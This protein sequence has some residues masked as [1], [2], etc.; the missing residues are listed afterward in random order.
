MGHNR[1]KAGIYEILRY[2]DMFY[3][4]FT[5]KS[6]VRR[7][8]EDCYNHWVEAQSDLMVKLLDEDVDEYIRELFRQEQIRKSELYKE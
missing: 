5:M 4:S 2:V 6:W 8:K 7:F 3:P 1:L